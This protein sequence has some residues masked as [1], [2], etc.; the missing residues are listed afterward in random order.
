VY[1]IVERLANDIRPDDQ[2]ILGY[3]AEHQK[4]WTKQQD[5]VLVGTADIAAEDEE[6][7]DSALAD[8]AILDVVLEGGREAELTQ[9]VDT[10][11]EHLA[12]GLRTRAAEAAPIEPDRRLGHPRHLHNLQHRPLCRRRHLPHLASRNGRHRPTRQERLHGGGRD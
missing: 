2:T 12:V 4:G 6:P 9:R 7:E 8:V 5:A 11:G 1:C 3:T 10:V